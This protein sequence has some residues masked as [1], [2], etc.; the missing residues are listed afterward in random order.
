MHILIVSGEG[1][2][3]GYIQDTGIGLNFVKVGDIDTFSSSILQNEIHEIATYASAVNKGICFTSN[4]KEVIDSIIRHFN[5]TSFN[6][7][8]LIKIYRNNSVNVSTIQ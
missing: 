7:I 6:K 5:N 1:D 8:E 2:L 4:R 3:R